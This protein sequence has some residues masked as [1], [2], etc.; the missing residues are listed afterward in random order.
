M[1]RRLIIFSNMAWNISNFRMELVHGLIQDGWEIHALAPSDGYE[2]KYQAFGVIHHHVPLSGRGMNPLRELYSFLSILQLYL[3]I[4]PR[5]A[6]HFTIKPNIYGGLVCRFLSIPAVSNITGLGDIFSRKGIFHRLITV[7]YK[8]ALSTSCRVFFQNKKDL[9]EINHTGILPAGRARLLP[10]SGVDTHRFVPATRSGESI[11]FLMMARLLVDKGVRHFMEASIEL[12]E[13]FPQARFVIVGPTEDNP[14]WVSSVELKQWSG[15]K[16]C[17]WK[18]K[19]D[20]PLS[21]LQAADVFVLPTFYNEGLPRSLLEAGACS[22]VAVS[23]YSRGVEELVENGVDGILCKGK[24]TAELVQALSRVLQM[25]EMERKL[26]G[27]KLRS[28]IEENFNVTL[29][30]ERYREAIEPWKTP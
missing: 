25:S 20:A 7:L 2:K 22:L 29:V 23:T 12:I 21:E 1:K 28:K 18:G 19:S 10:G 16:N 6:L 14:G 5:V 3:A 26:M 8:S 24:S 13:R 4:R 15:H 30:V 9:A 11:T 27:N 17:V